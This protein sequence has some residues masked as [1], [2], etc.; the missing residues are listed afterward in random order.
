MDVK[1]RF[2]YLRMMKKRYERADCKTKGRLLD[3]MEA[4][5]VLTRKHL[6]VRMNGPDPH[7]RKRR[8]ERSRYYGEDVEEAIA[9]IADT[10]DWICVERLKP[11]P[12]RPSQ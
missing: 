6:I 1:E 4:T 12:P 9:I 10:L 2:K 5:T 8:R 7:R 3:E 11:G